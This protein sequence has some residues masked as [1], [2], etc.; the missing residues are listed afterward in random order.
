MTTKDY[1]LVADSMRAY[2]GSLRGALNHNEKLNAKTELE[3][4][5]RK[6]TSL[7]E[8]KDSKFNLNKFMTYVMQDYK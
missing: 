8:N 4:L 6:F 1:M 2:S 3:I 5:A 7:I